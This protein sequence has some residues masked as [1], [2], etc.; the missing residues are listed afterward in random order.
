VPNVASKKHELIPDLPVRV[1]HLRCLFE[2]FLGYDQTGMLVERGAL[3]KDLHFYA[4]EGRQ[5]I[6]PSFAIARGPFDAPADDP[7]AAFDDA[8]AAAAPAPAVG[9]SPYPGARG[10]TPHDT[11]L[12]LSDEGFVAETCSTPGTAAFRLRALAGN[13][14]ARSRDGLRHGLL[15]PIARAWAV[16][17]LY[18]MVVHLYME[19]FGDYPPPR[20]WLLLGVYLPY[21]A[22]PVLVLARLRDDR[23]SSRMVEL[24]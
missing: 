1:N 15:A 4:E 3:P 20:P 21:A 14:R 10:E 11:S 16:A 7:F 12:G 9:Q 19:Y 6:R 23:P 5:D 17:M 18:S 8:P 2:Q 22:L 24:E 13:P